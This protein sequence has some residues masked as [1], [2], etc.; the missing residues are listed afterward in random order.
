MI[1]G[2]E[3]DNV[4]MPDVLEEVNSYVIADCGRIRFRQVNKKQNEDREN[5]A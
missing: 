4:D 1:I 5:A 2:L 3:H